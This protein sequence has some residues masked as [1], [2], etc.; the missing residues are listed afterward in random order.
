MIYAVKHPHPPDKATRTTANAAALAAWERK[1]GSSF[2]RIKQKSLDTIQEQAEVL[3][4]I[5]KPFNSLTEESLPEAKRVCCT[6]SHAS[7]SIVLLDGFNTLVMY[8]VIQ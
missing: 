6:Y 7:D 5:G 8:Y 4:E 2:L 1:G 3:F